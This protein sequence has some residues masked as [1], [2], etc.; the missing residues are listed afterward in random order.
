MACTNLWGLTGDTEITEVHLP[1]AKLSK[2]ADKN[3]VATSWMMAQAR[4]DRDVPSEPLG[5]FYWS[6]RPVTNACNFARDAGGFPKG[7]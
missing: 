4:G 3:A 5:N 2:Y 7:E 1:P 6:M